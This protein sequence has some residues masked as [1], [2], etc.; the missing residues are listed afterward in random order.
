MPISCDFNIACSQRLRI[1]SLRRQY[2]QFYRP[3]IYICRVSKNNIEN[4]LGDLDVIMPN[5]IGIN[6]PQILNM[7]KMRNCLMALF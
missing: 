1:K 4:G 3:Y 6:Y 5:F 2:W 7:R